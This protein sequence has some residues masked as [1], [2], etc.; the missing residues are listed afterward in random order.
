M[1]SCK[2]FTAILEP[3][4]RFNKIADNKDHFN[5]TGHQSAIGCLTYTSVATRPDSSF[6]VGVP[7]QHISKPRKVYCVRVNCIIRYIKETLDYGLMHQSKGNGNVHLH[8][9]VD[10]NWLADVVL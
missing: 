5:I 2:P 9:Y 3:G 8:G 10:V 7:S 6:L 1:G 4:N